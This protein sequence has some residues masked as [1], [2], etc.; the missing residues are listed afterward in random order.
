MILA[1]CSESQVWLPPAQITS[2]T[3]RLFLRLLGATGSEIRLQFISPSNPLGH[4]IPSAGPSLCLQAGATADLWS[5]AS[6]APG[7]P[8]S[9][10]PQGAGGAAVKAVLLVLL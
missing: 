1:L 4:S 6:S 8:G 7:S 2:Q 10:E 5:K 9:A 3:W